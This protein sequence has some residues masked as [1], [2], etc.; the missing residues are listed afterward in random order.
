MKIPYRLSVIFMASALSLL[1]AGCFHTDGAMKD[2]KTVSQYNPFCFPVKFYVER[3]ELQNYDDTV[4]RLFKIEEAEKWRSGLLRF[5]PEFFSAGPDNALPVTFSITPDH[6]GT[7]Y[8]LAG[9]ALVLLSLVSLGIIPISNDFDGWIGVSVRLGSGESV[10]LREE[11]WSVSWRNRCNMGIIGIFLPTRYLLT[12]LPDAIFENQSGDIPMDSMVRDDR[13]KD[14]LGLFVAALHRLPPDKVQ[15]L[16][17]S[18][19]KRRTQLLE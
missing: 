19:M 8:N 10:T 6:L 9:G 14:F 15:E 1:A 4:T 3:I 5:Y 16:Y 11:Q 12:K 13:L 18:R 17:L 7:R 2:L